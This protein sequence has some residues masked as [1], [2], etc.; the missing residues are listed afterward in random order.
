MAKIPPTLIFDM[1]NLAF[2]VGWTFQDF[3][4]KQGRPT[5]VIWGCVKEIL[6]YIKKFNPQ[7]VICCFDHPSGSIYRRKV[8][9][10]YKK[11][12]PSNVK[13]AEMRERVHDQL[14]RLPKV[15]R[16]LP[17]RCV[18]QKGEEGDDLMAHYATAKFIK[19]RKI[20]ITGDEDMLQLVN[21]KVRV[22][23]TNKEMVISPKNFKDMIG[24]EPEHF[25]D[26]KC[27]AGDSSDKVPGIKGIGWKYGCSI[28][29]N[30]GNLERALSCTGS[31]EMAVAEKNRIEKVREEWSIIHRNRKLMDLASRKVKIKKSS[32][33]VGHWN[34]IKF[35][36]FCLRRG[37]KSILLNMG[38]Y[39]KALERLE[40]RSGG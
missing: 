25:V 31:E 18:Q 1:N 28:V 15:L 30:W 24:C 26:V 36:K 38:K 34:K 21:K 11:R 23:L 13:Q 17:V 40:N 33:Q 5:G 20:I 29:N 27:M 6:R 4:D 12:D 10:G 2:R 16:F 14:E 37:Y 7:F 39:Y 9:P 35:R 8:F 22:Y 3:E 32:L 19:G